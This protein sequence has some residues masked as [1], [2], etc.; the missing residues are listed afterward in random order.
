M[1]GYAMEVVGSSQVHKGAA[2]FLPVWGPSGVEVEWRVARHCRIRS[3]E[4]TYK[5][6]K[7]G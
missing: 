7:S 1:D 6:T 2:H 5:R 4:C 3:V